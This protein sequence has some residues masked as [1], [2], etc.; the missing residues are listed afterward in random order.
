MVKFTAVK[1]APLLLSV[2]GAITL[3]ACTSN[4]HVPNNHHVNTA[5]S[6]GY[7]GA[8]CTGPC[9]LQTNLPSIYAPTYFGQSYYTPA[10]N[11]HSFYANMPM[12][13]VVMD[14][15]A[16]PAGHVMDAT[17]HAT[18]NYSATQTT[19]TQQTTATT[20]PAGTTIQSDGTCM[21]SS[22]SGTAQY[23]TTTTSSTANCPAG[24]TPQAD[25]TC[26]Q[27]ATSYTMHTTSGYQPV[28][29]QNHTVL[30]VRK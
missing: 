23:T 17:G 21:T 13:G 24:T 22:T 29:T 18:G 28:P 6:H 4:H 30:P 3:S 12:D 26:M 27:T 19:S 11:P 7:Y 8:N 15:G 14:H 16:Y 20:C 10:Y 9:R 5:F 25:G 1:K 2:I